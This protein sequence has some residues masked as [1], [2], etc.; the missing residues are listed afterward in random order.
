[1]GC[2]ELWFAKLLQALIERCHN[3]QCL[4]I[5]WL[6]WQQSSNQGN[7]RKGC[8]IVYVY[9]CMFILYLKNLCCDSY[10]ILNHFLSIKEAGR[11]PAYKEMV[12]EYSWLNK[13]V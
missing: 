8:Q 7:I 2:K 1:M 4:T 11:Y 3:T 9:W 12:A 5:S 13:R 10:S 6:F